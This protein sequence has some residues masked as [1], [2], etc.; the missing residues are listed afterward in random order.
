MS[1]RDFFFFSSEQQGQDTGSKD[2]AGIIL[3]PSSH[4]HSCFLWEARARAR[5]CTK[6]PQACSCLLCKRGLTG[7][8]PVGVCAPL[9]LN[10]E[11][12]PRERLQK[13]PQKKRYEK[14]RHYLWLGEGEP[15]ASSKVGTCWCSFSALAQKSLNTRGKRPPKERPGKDCRKACRLRLSREAG[16]VQWQP[17]GSKVQSPGC[18][19]CFLFKV[20]D[21]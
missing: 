5:W 8:V 3:T 11:L 19:I 21:L 15:E 16:W 10:T 2:K 6:C 9:S 13:M 1:R 18:E 14:P 7:C 4:K 20:W 12:H 17:L